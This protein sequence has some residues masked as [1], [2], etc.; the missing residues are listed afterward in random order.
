MSESKRNE[1][2]PIEDK[3]RENQLRRFGFVTKVNNYTN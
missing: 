3:M 1:F 2:A